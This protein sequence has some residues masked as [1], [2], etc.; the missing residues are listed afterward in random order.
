MNYIQI[1]HPEEVLTY[2]IER[3]TLKVILLEKKYV[4][5]LDIVSTDEIDD[6]IPDDALQYHFYQVRFFIEDFPV[7]AQT[8]KELIG[9]SIAIPKGAQEI[10]DEEDQLQ[11]VYYS[12]LSTENGDFETNDNRLFFNKEAS[13]D[14]VLKWEG[15]CGD[16]TQKSD[17]NIRFAITY[18]FPSEL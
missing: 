17:E 15:T 4:L 3:G 11:T 12:I 2:K 8:V 13:N 6:E 5:M 1:F 14:V 18:K 7:E 9:K 10:M 16:F